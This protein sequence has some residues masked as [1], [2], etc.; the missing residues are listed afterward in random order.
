M[1]L[2]GEDEMFFQQAMKPDQLLKVLPNVSE[3][4]FIV[5]A[6]LEQRVFHLAIYKY[7]DCYFR[8]KDVRIFQQVKEILQKKQ[9]DQSELLPYIEQALED[10]YYLVLDES[11]VQMDLSLLSIAN[12]R[13][14]I[15]FYYYE[16]VDGFQNN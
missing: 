3:C 4:F 8:L 16:F 14:P 5:E 15:S 9:G 1:D 6:M 12:V 7:E 10:N 11:F 13:K 2:R